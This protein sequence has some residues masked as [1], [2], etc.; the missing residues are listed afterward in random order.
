MRILIAEDSAVYTH[1]LGSLLTAWGYEVETVSN[2]EDAL[3]ALVSAGAPQL[4][5]LDWSMPRASGIKVC[6]QVRASKSKHYTYILLLTGHTEKEDLIQAFEA[7]VDDYL[8]KPFNDRELE[9]RLRAGRRIVALHDNLV[10][11]SDT[12]RHQACHDALTGIWNR[13][14]ILDF[15]K[16]QLA[17][18][19][20][21]GNSPVSV[22]LADV[23]H[24]K[25][26]NDSYGHLAGDVV[27]RET[28]QRIRR[29]IRSYDGAGRYGG[30]EFAIVL[31]G[32]S[33]EDAVKRADQ[34]RSA[35]AA[36]PIEGFAAPIAVTVSMGVATATRPAD[37]DRV[38]AAA[39]GAL[40]QAKANGRN[41]VEVA[42][43]LPAVS[44]HQS[45]E[46][47][48]PGRQDGEGFLV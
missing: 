7:G 46:E 8:T 23:D 3:V 31:P 30:E 19:D 6:R 25:Q 12:L 26:V 27:L 37:L 9:A 36:N 11:I 44:P 15:L 34:M 4:A 43:D 29:G 5:I 39:D 21:E 13:A 24:F 41:R 47:C 32:C 33:F 16:R 28:A 14:A 42:L 40:Y 45:E 22:I 2:G 20:R 48:R 17:R 1:L 10:S 35:L 38:L 18:A